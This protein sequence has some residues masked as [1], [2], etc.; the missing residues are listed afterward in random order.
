MRNWSRRLV[1]TK[2]LSMMGLHTDVLRQFAI[3]NIVLKVA[4]G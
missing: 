4:P 1:N 3:E 2:I